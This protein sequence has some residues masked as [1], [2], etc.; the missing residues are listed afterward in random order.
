MNLVHRA[1][2]YPAELSGGEEQRA[3]IARALVTHPRV[4]LADEPTG[5]LDSANRD[6][7]LSLFS[8]FHQQGT[9]VVIVTHNP[10]IALVAQRVLKIVDGKV[11]AE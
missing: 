3:A 7:I 9:T 1:K 4:I 8:R 11:H 2:H 6:Q 5:N 10:T